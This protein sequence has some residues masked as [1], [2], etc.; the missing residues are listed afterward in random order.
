[1]QKISTFNILNQSKGFT[2]IEIMLAIIILSIGLLAAAHMQVSAIDANAMSSETTI[3]LNLAEDLME[4]LLERK[5][6]PSNELDDVTA[7]NNGLNIG[8]FGGNQLDSLTIIDHAQNNL[9][10][11]GVINGQA[12]GPS[13]RRI[14]NIA[15]SPAGFAELNDT[16]VICVIVTWNGDNQRVRLLGVRSE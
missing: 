7:A 10:A 1:M 16:K 3:A 14:W 11:A 13:F 6:D 9:D 4:D 12:I 8:N 2:L 5:K 15:D